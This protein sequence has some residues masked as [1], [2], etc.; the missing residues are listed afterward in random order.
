MK[1]QES[2]PPQE[3]REEDLSMVRRESLT[4][5]TCPDAA[6]GLVHRTPCPSTSARRDRNAN[7]ATLTGDADATRASI[8]VDIKSVKWP[9]RWPKHDWCQGRLRSLLT[10]VLRTDF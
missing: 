1:E 8:N 7:G 4:L 9:I 2:H 6:L 3:R 10:D 5:T